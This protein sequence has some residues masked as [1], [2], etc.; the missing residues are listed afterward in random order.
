MKTLALRWSTPLAVVAVAALFGSACEITVDAGPYAAHEDKRF[1]VN[2]TPDL[3]LATF[4]G[5]VEVRS[6]DRSEV[7]VEIQKRA[8]DKTQA[9]AIRVS[10][11]QSGNTITLK[12]HKPD[13]PQAGQRCPVEDSG[14]S[15]CAGLTHDW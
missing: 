7:L 5:S 15:R 4:D 13:G 11:E 1:Q 6:W 8:S 10:A 14:V 9:E 3:S 2:G 12:V